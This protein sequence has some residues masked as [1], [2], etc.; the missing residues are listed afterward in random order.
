MAAAPKPLSGFAS[1]FKTEQRVGDRL[2][3]DRLLDDRTVVLRDGSLMQS[4]YLEGFAFETADTDEVNH[5]QIVRAAALRAI[6]S[7]RFVLYHHIIR[8]RVTVTMP[9]VYDDPVCGLIQ[10][11]WQERLKSRQLFVNDLFITVV[12]RN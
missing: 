2:P 1:W 6:G 7:S 9:A 5:R 3:Y 10:Q 11:Q 12:R 8:R 4:I